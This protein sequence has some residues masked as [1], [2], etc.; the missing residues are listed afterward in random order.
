MSTAE[1]PKTPSQQEK[2]GTSNSGRKVILGGIPITRL[3]RQQWVKYLVSRCDK[4]KADTGPTII[5]SANGQVLA[6]AHRDLK[7][8]HALLKGDVID[9]DG[10][11]L[12]FASK[13]LFKTPLSERVATT[14]TFHDAAAVAEKNGISFFFFGATQNNIERAVDLVRKIYPSLHIAGFRNGY[15]DPADEIAICEEIR[16]HK[17]DVLWVGLGAPKQELFVIRNIRNLHGIS[18][19]KTCG[20]LFDHLQPDAKRAPNWMQRSGLEWLYRTSQNPKKFFWRYLTTNW[21]AAWL[22]LTNSHESR[23]T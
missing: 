21:I 10:Q 13:L 3:D 1:S 12:V 16:N 23:N 7:F 22:L 2:S 8:R 20:G 19:I 15:F 17:P 4:T 5:F 6:L 11:S 9:A 14:D 18:A